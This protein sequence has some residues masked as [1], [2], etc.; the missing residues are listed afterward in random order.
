M[1]ARVGRA[2]A[3]LSPDEQRVAAVY[4]SNYGEAGA[5]DYFGARYGLPPAVSGHNSYFSWGPPPAERGAVL[6]SVGEDKDD[7][8]KTFEDVV[9]VDVT[10]DAFAMPYEN[11]LP[12]YVCRKPKRDWREVWPSMKHF[13]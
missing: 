12:I 1:A 11:H 6:I 4:G 7:L 9:Q 13:I 2:Y 3:A 5:L 10:D 8:E